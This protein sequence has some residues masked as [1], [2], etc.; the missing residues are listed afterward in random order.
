[1]ENQESK[2]GSY[3]MILNDRIKDTQKSAHTEEPGH[4]DIG[5]YTDTHIKTRPDKHA[6]TGQESAIYKEKTLL[7]DHF[8]L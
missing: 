7:V 2:G 6:P 8:F 3:L 1:M 4:G 5:R